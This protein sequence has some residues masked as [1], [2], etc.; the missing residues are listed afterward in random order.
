MKFFKKLL[1]FILII[2]F[3]LGF[4]TLNANAEGSKLK[5]VSASS[6]CLIEAESGKVLYSKNAEKRLPMAST[7]KIMTAILALESGVSLDRVITVS[8]DCVGIEGSSLYLKVGERITFEALLYGLLLSSAN[9]A[10]NAIAVTVGGSVEDF[11][12]LMNN[13]ASSLGLTNTH[14]AN[15]H[16]LNDENHYTTALDLARLMAYCV[17]NKI[18]VTISGC[19]KRVFSADEAFSRVMINHNRLLRA[20]IGIIAGKTGFTKVSGR[21]LV[22]CAQNENLRLIAV[23][24]NAPNDWQDHTNLYEFGFSSY[25]RLVFDSISLT[26][27]IISGKSDTVCI[28]SEE[29]SVFQAKSLGQISVEINAPRFLYAEIE[30]GEKVGEVIYRQNGKIIAKSTLFSCE[31]IEKAKKVKYKFNLFEWLKNLIKGFFKWKK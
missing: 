29:C 9:D 27:P 12:T 22:T 19:E 3:L 6:A 11:V 30:E 13:K 25:E 7:T 20:N 31:K 18:F 1:A 14:F 26:L 28:K 5:G 8:K 4:L 2:P 10:A 24:L 21:C 23:T 15:P 16:G 17:E